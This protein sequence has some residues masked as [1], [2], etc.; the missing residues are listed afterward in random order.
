MHDPAW[1]IVCFPTSREP[2]LFRPGSFH[3]F[4]R[5][6]VPIVVVVLPIIVPVII[7]VVVPIVVS[8]VQIINLIIRLIQKTIQGAEFRG[9][10]LTVAVGSLD[11]ILQP[12]QLIFQRLYFLLK[13]FPCLRASAVLKFRTSCTS[14]SARSS[15]PLISET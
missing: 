6:V 10:Q 8:V 13:R 9:R 12:L 2:G 4:C 15:K 5:S 3:F 1:R 7:V 11:L 14:S